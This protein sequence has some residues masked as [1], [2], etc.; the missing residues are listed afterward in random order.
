VCVQ[1][2]GE[3]FAISCVNFDIEYLIVGSNDLDF[4]KRRAFLA[5]QLGLGGFAACMMLLGG[6]DSLLQRDLG[7]GQVGYGVIDTCLV[8]VG[9]A[10]GSSDASSGDQGGE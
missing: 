9:Y 7:F 5:F 1:L 2:A 10:T 3:H 4:V 6:C 8:G